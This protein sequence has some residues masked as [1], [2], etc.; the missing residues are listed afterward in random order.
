MVLADLLFALV[1]AVALVLILGALGRRGPWPGFFWVFL[2][3]FLFTWV[4]GTWAAPYGPVLWGVSWM[5]FVLFGVILAFII[6]AAAPPRRRG[7]PGDLADREGDP[8]PEGTVGVAIGFFFWLA[9]IG[10]V[11]ALIARYAAWPA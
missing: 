7:K 3:I 4:M 8:M 1:I 2:L 5:P 6:A 10:L 9:L 11:A